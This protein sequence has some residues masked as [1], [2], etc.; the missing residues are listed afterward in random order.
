MAGVRIQVRRDTAANW[1]T[2]NPTL[3]EG[4]IGYETD[5]G[6]V[7]VGDGAS[8][9]ASLRYSFMSFDKALGFAGAPTASQVA[10]AL[11][12]RSCVILAADPGSAY[13]RTN[14]SDGDW[15][16]AL[17]VNGAGADTLTISTAGVVT[18]SI[19]SDLALAA[20]DRLELMAPSPADSTAADIQAAFK[21]LPA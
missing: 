7:K 6:L 5:T 19:A 3:T 14:P 8:A 10:W 1:T 13:A 4:E 18:W 17:Q 11:I 12:Q 21:V 20:G 2:A 16:A 15:V 9:W